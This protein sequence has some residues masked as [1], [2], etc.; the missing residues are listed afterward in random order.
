MLSGCYAWVVKWPYPEFDQK[1]SPFSVSVTGRGTARCLPGAVG[2]AQAQPPRKEAGVGG[3]RP[4]PQ[5]FL[6]ACWPPCV[7]ASLLLG[8][9]VSPVCAKAEG[10][11]ETGI[12]SVSTLAGVPHRLG[13]LQ[14]CP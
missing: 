12:L 6:S 9:A 13:R 2:G 14:P 8:P 11:A 4:S 7:S 5:A 3:P 10:E 1:Q